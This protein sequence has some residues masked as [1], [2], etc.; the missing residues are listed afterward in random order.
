MA[1]GIRHCIFAIFFNRV[2]EGTSLQS[3]GY[4]VAKA[5]AHC[6]EGKKIRP[7]FVLEELS[8]GFES[9]SWKIPF[10]KPK[11]STNLTIVVDD[12]SAYKVLT[13]MAHGERT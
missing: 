12:K 1:I 5:A 9:R 6:T 11:A 2:A 7:V 8:C 4:D 3:S 10:V 13:R